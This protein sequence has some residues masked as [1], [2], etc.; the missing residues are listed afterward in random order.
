VGTAIASNPFP[1]T[2]DEIYFGSSLVP[3]Q[4]ANVDIG[5]YMIAPYVLTGDQITNLERELSVKWGITL[6]GDV[7]FPPVPLIT[8][9]YD[10]SGEAFHPSVYDAGEG[11]VWP[12]TGSPQHR[13]W[14][15]MTPYPN[16]NDA[17]E[18]PSILV[19]D[20]RE[21]WTVPSG[22]T[23][24]I[25]PKPG[26]DHNA[27]TEIL[28]GQD[29]KLYVYYIDTAT[30]GY[31]MNVRSSSDGVTW[32]AETTLFNGSY[33]ACPTVFYDGSQYIMI[34]VD[35]ESTP[36]VLRYRTCA[37]PDGTW[38]AESSLS[39]SGTPSGTHPW[40]IFAR[41]ISDGSYLALIHFPPT[42]D[43]QKTGSLYWA[44][45]SNGTTW[46]VSDVEIDTGDYDFIAGT[47]YRSCFVEVG[48]GEYWVW[49]SGLD[50][51][52]QEARKEARTGLKHATR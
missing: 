23:N 45:S 22:L 34:Y 41:K 43:P 29:D 10:G 49:F 9:T 36:Y 44:T 27:D 26:T 30:T 24:P 25:D 28:H 11:N 19:S 16:T 40:N 31:N 21:T 32:S 2:W 52:I 1:H 35:A 47:I 15:A 33:A 48:S 17:Y 14:M 8:P 37:T 46:T 38:S 39:I 50:E 7:Y 42:T 12:S 13:Y 5:K 20:D 3:N 51:L 4:F 18:N 6:N